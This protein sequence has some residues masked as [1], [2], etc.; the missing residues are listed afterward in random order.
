MMKN[1]FGNST[2]IFGKTLLL[3]KLLYLC[4]VYPLNDKMI[5]G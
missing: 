3:E 4:N 2:K 1:V 5:V